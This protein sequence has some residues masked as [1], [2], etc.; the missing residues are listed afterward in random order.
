[1]AEK[2][3]GVSPIGDIPTLQQQEAA[4]AG[5]RAAKSLR[6]RYC[7]D[8]RAKAVRA[9]CLK[10]SP[11]SSAWVRDCGDPTCALW[12]YRMGRNPKPE[13]LRVAQVDKLGNVT[14]YISYE[15][16][17]AGKGNAWQTQPPQ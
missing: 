2:S 7:F 12:P 15:D 3:S 16:W 17:L 5:R 11:E 8:S 1:M 14:G 6:D 10:C 4:R 9:Y 13:D